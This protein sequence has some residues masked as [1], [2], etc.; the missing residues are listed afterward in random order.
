M[1]PKQLM[2]DFT[3]RAAQVEKNAA[4]NTIDR[5][6]ISLGS[7]GEPKTPHKNETTETMSFAQRD[8]EKNQRWLPSIP[9]GM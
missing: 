9:F 7:E 2:A 3:D 6:N 5:S 8:D 4:C 1:D